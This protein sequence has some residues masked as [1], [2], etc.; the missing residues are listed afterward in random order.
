MTVRRGANALA[1]AEWLRTRVAEGA[2]A[3]DLAAE[4]GVAT[5][6]VSAAW[7]EHAIGQVS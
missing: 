3:V 5:R 6:L 1:D 7:S 4:V 2:T